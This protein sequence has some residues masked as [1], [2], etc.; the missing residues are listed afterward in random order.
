LTLNDDLVIFNVLNFGTNIKL[1][2]QIPN[3][4]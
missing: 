2:I 3:I 4:K 1:M